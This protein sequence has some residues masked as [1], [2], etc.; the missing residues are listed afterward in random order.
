MIFTRIVI[1]GRLCNEDLDNLRN[2]SPNTNM[3]VEMAKRVTPQGLTESRLLARQ[4]RD[5]FPA[6]F[7][8]NQGGMS[9]QDYVVIFLLIFSRNSLVRLVLRSDWGSR[10][11]GRRRIRFSS[12]AHLFFYACAIAI[13]MWS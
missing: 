4:I 10:N 5:A 13:L 7:S 11:G 3:T 2:W 6:L 1:D 9:A 8:A 12:S